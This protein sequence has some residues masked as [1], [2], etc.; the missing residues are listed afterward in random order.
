MASSLE[1]WYG[2]RGETQWEDVVR[3]EEKKQEQRQRGWCSA[4]GNGN[5]MERRQW[6][7]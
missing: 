5:K 2:G 1:C 3:G 4:R 6:E 7:R